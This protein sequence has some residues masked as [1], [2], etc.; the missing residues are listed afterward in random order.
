MK[1]IKSK[2]RIGSY[3]VL[4]FLVVDKRP[5]KGESGNGVGTTILDF[6]RGLTNFF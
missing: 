6:L 3:F 2:I 5:K 1:S 4:G